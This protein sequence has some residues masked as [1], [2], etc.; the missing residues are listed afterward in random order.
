MPS[1]KH[2]SR[3]GLLSII[4]CSLSPG[5]AARITTEIAECQILPCICLS[6]MPT[7]RMKWKKGEKKHLSRIKVC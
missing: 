4:S 1:R 6:Q 3:R 7:L 2:S 5:L